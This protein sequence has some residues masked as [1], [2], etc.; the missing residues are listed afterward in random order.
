MFAMPVL[1]QDIGSSSVPIEP[2]SSRSTWLGY[3]ATYNNCCGRRV[4]RVIRRCRRM[5]RWVAFSCE[6]GGSWQLHAMDLQTNQELRLSTGDC[7]SISPVWTPDSRRLIY[8]T[9]C[10]RGLGLTALAEVTVLH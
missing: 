9:D 10:G 7:N 5:R 3:L 4:R 6:Q 2:D 1:L 8:A